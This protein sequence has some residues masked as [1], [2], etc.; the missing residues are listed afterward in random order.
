MNKAIILT[1]GRL[2]VNDAKTAHGLIRTSERFEI[3]GVIAAQNAGKDAGEILDGKRRNIPVFSTVEEAV[4]AIPDIKYCIVGVATPG[5]IFPESMLLMLKTAIQHRLNIINGLHDFLN[6]RPDF[7]ALAETCQVT[8]TD[9]RRPKKRADLH[10]WTGA[11]YDLKCPIVAVMGMDCAMGKR[12]TTRFVMQACVEAGI[13]PGMI[14]TG[15]TGW[16]QGGQYGFIFDST[17]NDFISGELEHAILSCH[18][19]ENPDVIFIEGQSALRNP[20]GPC[21]SEFL[22]SGNAKH[23]ILVCAPKRIFYNHDERWGRIPSAESEIALM[24]HYGTRVLALVLNTE[25]CTREEAFAFQQEYQARLNIP[26]LLPLEAG[27]GPIV[28]LIRDIL[29][30]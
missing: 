23:A 13:K 25:Y 26:V 4:Q 18:K 8:L 5:G 1:G 24:A 28:P 30:K 12:T 20:S 21:G 3:A 15:Q 10:F 2:D 7:A 6:D 17:L 14:Y 9:V 11:V 29:Q 27:V 22:V 19:A 16:M